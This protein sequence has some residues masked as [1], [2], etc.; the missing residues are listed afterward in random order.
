MA[1]MKKQNVDYVPK[2][3]KILS[4]EQCTKFLL[5]ATDDFLLCKVALVFGLYG[6]CRRDELLRLLISDIEDHGKYIL[7]QLRDTK[8]HSA[9]SFVVPDSNGDVNPYAIYKKYA[10]LRP[11]KISTQRFFLG[12]RQG[13]CIAQPAGMHTIGGIPKKVAEFLK[14]EDADQY[15]GH[16][17]RRSGASM[18]AESCGNLLSVKQIG[19]WKSTKVAEGYVEQ[20]L[21]SKMEVANMFFPSVDNTRENNLSTLN[22][23]NEAS[24]SACLNEVEISKSISDAG[25]SITGNSRCTISVYLCDHNVC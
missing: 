5:E 9:R 15:T 23:S 21:K 24:T 13:K 20:S 14:L 3:S 7:V 17:L 11:K 2:K 16:C 1:F 6:A 18:V 10:G 8:T 19:G 25:L 12:Y 22:A 4:A